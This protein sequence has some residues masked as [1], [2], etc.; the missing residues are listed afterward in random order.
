MMP[1]AEWRRIE[2]GKNE[3]IIVSHPRGEFSPDHCYVPGKFLFCPMR[4]DKQ[5][6]T[7]PSMS[8]RQENSTFCSP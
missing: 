1:L 7:C 6:K 4:M 8:P 2:G 3:A 5:R